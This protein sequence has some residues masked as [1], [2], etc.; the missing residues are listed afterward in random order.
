MDYLETVQVLAPLALWLR[1][2]HPTAGLVR[3]AEVER[4]LTA[5]YMEE[6]GRARGPARQQGRAFLQAVRSYSNLLVERGQGQYGFLHLTFEEMLAAKGIAARAQLG[7]QGAV[8]VIL[9]HLDEPAWHE[10][11]LLAVGALGIVMQQPLAAGAVLRALCAAD[12]DDD[13]R[14]YAVVLAGEALLDA[15]DVAV[16]RKAAA[17]VTR[18]LVATMQDAAVP[19]R[20]RREAGLVLGTLGWRPEDLDAFV[21]IPPGS[22]LYG[23]KK[24]E[25]EIAQRYWIGRYP[26]TNAQYARFVEAGGYKQQAYWSADGWAWRT[27]FYDSESPKRHREQISK[28]PLKKRNQPFYWD[29]ENWNNPIF[30]V[31]GVTKFEAEAYCEWLQRHS[32]ALGLKLKVWEAELTLDLILQPGTFKIQLP[33]EEKWERA[34]RGIEG[35]VYPWGNEFDLTRL[36]CADVWAGKKMDDKTWQEWF[37]RGGWKQ[38]GTTA[39]CTYARRNEFVGILDAVGNSWEWT[40]SLWDGTHFIVRGGAWDSDH[41]FARCTYRHEYSPDYFRSTIG[42]RVE[43]SLTNM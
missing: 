29:N 40:R 41:R 4:W 36:N 16:G 25:R 24:E 20:N 37:E 30:P 14:G 19:I 9:R 33:S 15:G 22:F 26:V 38:A 17:Q 28:R 35:W 32:E 43:I 7:P 23:D 2:T 12:L 42:F 27:G 10:T 39:V 18:A 8:D 21:E 11:I 5:Y 1:E 3:R 6:W 34:C 13:Q 31:V